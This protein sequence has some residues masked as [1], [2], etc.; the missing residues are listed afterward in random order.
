MLCP[1]VPFDPGALGVSAIG[2]HLVTTGIGGAVA[3]HVIDIIGAG[4]YPNVADF[5]EEGRRYGFSRKFSPLFPYAELEPGS[6]LLIAHP[7]GWP[8]AFRQYHTPPDGS[9]FGG[10]RKALPD[11]PH[12]LAPCCGCWYDDVRC[13]PEDQGPELPS[14]DGR[15]ITRTMPAFTYVARR[16]PEG[17]E[18]TYTH[19]I[20]AVL[21][22]T[23]FVVV[24]DPEEGT[25]N[26]RVEHLAKAGIHADLVDE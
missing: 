23:R 15:A 11:R 5:L 14:S 16:P 13:A 20:V 1:P 3:R 24:R 9:A 4:D 7:R 22:I 6:R 8:K 25:H 21:P 17:V 12:D 2:Q 19:A 18:T 26:E 10:C